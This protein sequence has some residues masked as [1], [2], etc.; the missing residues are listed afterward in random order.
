MSEKA[1]VFPLCP[2]AGIVIPFDERF[3]VLGYRSLDNNAGLI[4]VIRSV[5]NHWKNLNFL[6]IKNSISGYE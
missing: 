6:R 3:R 5:F 4:P 2:Q 1:T